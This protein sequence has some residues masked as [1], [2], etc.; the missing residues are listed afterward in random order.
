MEFP[1][2]VTA[3]EDGTKQL[4]AAL[5]K[6][7]GGLGMIVMG[8]G[9]VDA[10]GNPAK[11]MV[12]GKPGSIL[13]ALSYFQTSVDGK[14]IPG[15]DQIMA[16]T[17]KIGEG[18]NLAKDGISA[19]LNTMQSV[20]AIVSALKDNAS[21]ANTFLGKPEG[22]EAMVAYVYQTPKVDRVAATMNYGLGIIVFVLIILFAIG[23]PPKQMIQ[24]PDMNA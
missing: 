4:S 20:P 13:Y 3:L 8:M 21:Q 18:S 10:K 24:S 7:E 5:G 6:T 16:G 9:N 17:T 14:V 12:N 1:A 11:V 23:R 19:G 22:A 15:I 2:S